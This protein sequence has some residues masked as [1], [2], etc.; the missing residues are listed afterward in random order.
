MK[1]LLLEAAD[2]LDAFFAQPALIERLRAA[3]VRMQWVPVA[4]RLP[5]EFPCRVWLLDDRGIVECWNL[6][7]P[8]R[9]QAAFS[10]YATHWQYVII[11]E[12]P[13]MHPEDD[14]TP[15]EERRL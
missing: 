11:P 7:G 12:P 9:A 15:I 13:E 14:A 2:L 6:H 1:E 3:A 8:A 4:E 10:C 5:D